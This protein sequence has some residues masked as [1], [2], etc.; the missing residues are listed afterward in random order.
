[1]RQ[2]GA[3]NL[4]YEDA[5]FVLVK[6]EKTFVRRLLKWYRGNRRSFPWREASRT[7][8]EVLVAELMLQRTIAIK[9]GGVYET[10]LE[11]YPT[12]A[13][14]ATAS[15]AEMMGDIETLGLHAV[16]AKRFKELGRKILDEH[17]GEIPREKDAL[18]A[19]PGVGRYIANAVRCFAFGEDAALVDTNFSRVLGRVFYGDEKSL[20]PE[21]LDSWAF[22]QGL[23]PGG[24]CR[25]FNYALLDFASL[26]CKAKGARHEACPVNDICAFVRP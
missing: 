19:L 9:V 4:K 7:P 25:E 24:R 10:F 11:K 16:R 26:V 3:K 14:L 21:K 1:A 5:E 13:A 18:E 20:P 2:W 8:Y 15:V 6:N 17:G 12:P 23:I 22:A